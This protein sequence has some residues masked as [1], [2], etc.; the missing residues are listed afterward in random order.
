MPLE[1]IPKIR[2]EVPEDLIRL[3]TFIKGIQKQILSSYDIS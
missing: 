1:I 2:P 3:E